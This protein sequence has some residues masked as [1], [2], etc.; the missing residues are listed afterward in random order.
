MNPWFKTSGSSLMSTS[1]QWMSGLCLSSRTPYAHRVW[2]YPFAT[3]TVIADA[4]AKGRLESAIA[5]AAAW[6]ASL[7]LNSTDP[8]EAPD[9][10]SMMMST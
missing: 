5:F 1:C 8:I 10:A 6:H 9:P 4:P 7:V 3:H 2:A